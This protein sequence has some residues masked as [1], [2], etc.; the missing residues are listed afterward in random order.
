MCNAT[1]RT[2]LYQHVR[3]QTTI[4]NV[5]GDEFYG[6]ELHRRSFPLERVLR[7]IQATTRRPWNRDTVQPPTRRPHRARG[8]HLEYEFRVGTKRYPRLVL[9]SFFLIRTMSALVRDQYSIMTGT[10]HK[11]VVN[12]TWT[13]LR[14]KFCSDISNV[15]LNNTEFGKCH[16]CHCV[17][18]VN[19][20]R[21]VFCSQ[22]CFEHC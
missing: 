13:T 21:F 19:N 14:N 16:T 1:Q 6:G 10:Q 22:E 3:D 7:R 11:D 12:D 4:G 20:G 17:C 2:H 9:K 18:S 8:A 5:F 15:I